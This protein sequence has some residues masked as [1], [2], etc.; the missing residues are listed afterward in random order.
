ME[1]IQ[2]PDPEE[3]CR[4]LEAYERNERRGCV[5]FEALDYVSQ[6]WG[7]SKGMAEGISKLIRSWNRFY[8]N[9][10]FDRLVNCIEINLPMLNE[11]RN[12]NIGSLSADDNEEIKQIFNQFLDALKR[13]SDNQKSAVSVAKAFGLLAPDFL[14]IW[15]S[16]IAWRYGC[17]YIFAE[18]A[19][20]E[21]VAFCW[22]MKEMAEKVRDYEC[23]RNPNPNRSLLKMIDEYNYS[24][25]TGMWI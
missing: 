10:N 15:D 13:K 6:F 19:A 25:F 7:D 5:Y 12:R 9:F 4:G 3:F 24:K 21:Y 18:M 8:A 16:T 1:S 22:K 20:P 17:L 14:P 11:F 23:V 2:I